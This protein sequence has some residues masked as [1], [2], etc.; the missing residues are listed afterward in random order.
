VKAISA[1]AATGDASVVVVEE[2][3]L[4]LRRSHEARLF[5][6]AVGE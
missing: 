6:C 4:G 1:I 3:V 5:T 2:A